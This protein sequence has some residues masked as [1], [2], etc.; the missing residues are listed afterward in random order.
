MSTQERDSIRKVLEQNLKSK[1]AE[2]YEIHIYR[3][4]KRIVE[5]DKFGEYIS[6]EILYPKIAYEKVAQLLLCKDRPERE[7]VLDDI[8][9][10][11]TGFD[12][13]PYEVY[14]LKQ[15]EECSFTAQG[16]KVQEGEFTCRKCKSKRCYWYQLQTRSGDEG[17]TVFY[18]CIKCK[19]RAK[20]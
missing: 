5:D 19:T 10:D 16:P 1:T 18:T 3:M 15:K 4:C 11:V 8:K 13:Y 2:K 20:R 9:N 14:R 7:K 6:M 12:A 17:M